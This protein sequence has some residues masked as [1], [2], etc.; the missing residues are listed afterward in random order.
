M[1]ILNARRTYKKTEKV[2]M[3][4]YR[5]S[6]TKCRKRENVFKCVKLDCCGICKTLHS[7]CV[8]HKTV[9]LKFLFWMAISQSQYLSLFILVTRIIQDFFLSGG[10]LVYQ[11]LYSKSGHKSCE[12]GARWACGSSSRERNNYEEI[13]KR[14]NHSCYSSHF[15]V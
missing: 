15:S 10:F 11:N 2:N 13:V 6:K 14:V 12:V 4:R 7:H 3:G 1:A 9:R 8:P 5:L